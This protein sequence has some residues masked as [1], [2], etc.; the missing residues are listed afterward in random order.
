MQKIKNTWS[1]LVD[2]GLLEEKEQLS[3]PAPTNKPF[4]PISSTPTTPTF[5]KKPE[6]Q[7]QIEE[8][9]AAKTWTAPTEKPEW[10]KFWFR[11]QAELDIM[12]DV[13]AQW[14]TAEDGQD[15]LNQ[16][17]AKQEWNVPQDAIETPIEEDIS[18]LD[19]WVKTW[20]AISGFADNLKFKAEE[21]DW[22]ITS[23]AKFFWNLP[24]DTLQLAGDLIGVASDP[25]GTVKSVE[26]FAG[27]LIETG[28][29]KTF[30]QDH[31]TS[32][33][34]RLISESVSTE[35]KKISDN[36]SILKD[37]AVENPADLLFSLTGGLW[38]AK[39]TA[40]SKWFTSLA[41]KLEKVE[42]I[43]NPI[44]IQKKAGT[45][46][47]K[48]AWPIAKLPWDIA[49]TLTAKTSW[50]NPETLTQLFKN[51]ELVNSWLSKEKTANKVVSAI[52]TRIDEVW[53]LGKEYQWVR[54]YNW[55][56]ATEK[57][58][59]DAIL[60]KFNIRLGENGKLDFSNS[61]IGTTGNKNAIESAY[62]LIKDRSLETWDNVLSLRQALDDTINY[63]TEATGASEKIVNALRGNVD[64]VAKES[65][66]NLRELDSKFGTEIKELNKVKSLI[67]DRAGDLKDTYIA[68]ISRLI[69]ERNSIKLER[70]EKLVPELWDE[71]RSLKALEDV[72]LAKGNKVGTYFQTATL[73]GW[74]GSAAFLWNPLLWVASLLV[75]S[76]TVVSNIVRGAGYS[77]KFVKN[78]TDK[79]KQGVKLTKEEAEVV[80][81]SVREQIN[82]TAI[83]W[84]E[85]PNIV[86]E[87]QQ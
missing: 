5:L 47:W 12:K 76:P 55:P 37:L 86:T 13:K 48:V 59:P 25:V 28:L 30:W 78:I 23:I 34:K 50:L 35:L 80:S 56:I 40:K 79:V 3:S 15:I 6:S 87:W 31:F 67:F 16:Y 58:T 32:D 11:S 19:I 27:S 9:I 82:D 8:H 81:K 85:I 54:E 17:R 43:T 33:E 44:T 77:A 18:W 7:V 57:I 2:Y 39:N 72:E 74:L 4:T 49:R 21:D 24:W 14:G 70:I 1:F 46:A 36:P 41:D 64:E 29:N 69:T 84:K 60:E 61:S 62:R 83:A 20:E 65:I 51:P 26:Q 52:D 38:V 68:D 53:D 22:K 45:V 73:W 66:P 10:E 42:T 71:I 63:K 75:T